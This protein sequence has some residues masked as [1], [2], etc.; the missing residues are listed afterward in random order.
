MNK[1]KTLEKYRIKRQ[2]DTDSYNFY[3]KIWDQQQKL[4]LHRQIACLMNCEKCGGY[5]S[6]CCGICSNCPHIT[7]LYVHPTK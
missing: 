6:N 2:Q 4:K 7:C 5:T 3:I 1:Y